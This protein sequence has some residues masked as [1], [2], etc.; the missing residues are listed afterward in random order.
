MVAVG[1]DGDVVDRAGTARQERDDV[2]AG[3]RRARDE[4]AGRR[5]HHRRDGGGEHETADADGQDLVGDLGVDVVLRLDAVAED[6]VR[7]HADDR[8][9]RAVEDAVD[10]G[11][12]A[13]ETRYLRGA[14]GEDALPDVLADEHAEHVDDEPR[15]DRLRVGADLAAGD[16]EVVVAQALADAGEAVGLDEHER[17]H[18]RED[19]DRLDDELH[20]VGQGDRPHAAD[21]GVHEHDGAA[22]GDADPAVEARQH[23]QDGGV[24]AGR[25]DDEE[26]R[27]EH[28]DD[29]GRARGALAAVAQFQHVADGVDAQLRD[30]AGEQQ[31]QQEHADADGDDEPHA[32]QPHLVAEADPADRG[33]ATEDDGRHRAGVEE[34]AE[35]AAGDEVVARVLGARAAPEPEAE[36]GDEVEDDDHE[37]E[38]HEGLLG[39]GWHGSGM[40]PR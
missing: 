26:H 18:E 14:R 5:R 17:Q 39:S 19:A 22:D 31:R 33:G 6:G 12:G 20:L 10:T 8:A 30:G 36:H 9:G 23:V 4:R 24:R 11:H 2:V 25:G 1:V 40:S 15:D 21:D 28:H 38:V 35:A 29:A 3:H 13:A 34:G 37:V 7:A 16:G 32:R 27:V